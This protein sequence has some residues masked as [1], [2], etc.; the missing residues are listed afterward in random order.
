[1]F[2]EPLVMKIIRITKHLIKQM[3]TCE[4][5]NNVINRSKILPYK[6]S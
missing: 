6:I 2:S 3:V 5:E 1:M 4:N